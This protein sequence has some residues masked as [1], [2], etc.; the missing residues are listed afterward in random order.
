MVIKHSEFV[1]EL[2]DALLRFK[3]F[4]LKLPHTGL[5]Y[6]PSYTSAMYFENDIIVFIT[7]RESPTTYFVA[8]ITRKCT[9]KGK[10]H[11][12]VQCIHRGGNRDAANRVNFLNKISIIPDLILCKLKPEHIK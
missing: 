1:H 3:K 10:T 12:D 7:Q 6:G 5:T 11:Y 2:L 9:K 8:R 4:R